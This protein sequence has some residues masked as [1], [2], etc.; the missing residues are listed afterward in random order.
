MNFALTKIL[1]LLQN[2]GY[3][4]RVE[5]AGWIFTHAGPAR[6]TSKAE[7]VAPWPLDFILGSPAFFEKYCA[8][9]A[10]Q[11]VK[12]ERNCVKIRGLEMKEIKFHE[13]RCV[14]IS[15][16]SEWDSFP[17]NRIQSQ[18]SNYA[19]PTTFL[20]YPNSEINVSRVSTV[21]IF[22]DLLFRTVGSLHP[23]NK[24]RSY[25]FHSFVFISSSI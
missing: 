19:A 22:A 17:T 15:F 11:Q 12:N 14:L 1:E 2:S 25:L 13:T 3:R 6:F 16:T 18:P 4:F 24:L 9:Y 20:V 23:L 21:K 7:V 8:N 5:M 10:V